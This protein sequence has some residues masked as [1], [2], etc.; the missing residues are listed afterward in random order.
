MQYGNE[1][2]G[3]C[4]EWSYGP[5]GRR[6][7]GTEGQKETAKALKGQARGR[8]CTPRA[9]V[10]E[11]RASRAMTREDAHKS[12]SVSSRRMTM[13]PEVNPQ[14]TGRAAPVIADAASEAR[15]SDRPRDV[16]RLDDAPERIP[17]L[18]RFQHLGVLGGGAPL[19]E[20]S[21]HSAGQD[22]VGANAVAAILLRQ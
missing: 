9:A 4:G 16:D 3:Q 8:D 11:R 13:L 2:N 10:P 18:E 6:D 12:S 1:A 17:A 15:L 5:E 19:P 14:L 21:A 20:R 7:G 22:D